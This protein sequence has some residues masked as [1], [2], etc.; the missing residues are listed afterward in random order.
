MLTGVVPF[1]HTIHTIHLYMY[2]AKLPLTHNEPSLYVINLQ[3]VEHTLSHNRSIYISQHTFHQ[4]TQAET[5][6]LLYKAS[7]TTVCMHLLY[8]ILQVGCHKEREWPFVVN[9]NQLSM[10]LYIDFKD[11]NQPQDDHCLFPCDNLPAKCSITFQPPYPTYTCNYRNCSLPT[12]HMQTSN[13]T[14]TIPINGNVQAPSSS[15]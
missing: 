2:N 7:L 12:S 11:I 9:V 8:C 3:F 6:L 4:T 13:Y 5:M 14:S 1:I 15:R 10:W